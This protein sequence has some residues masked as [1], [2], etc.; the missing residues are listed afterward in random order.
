MLSLVRTKN[1]KQKF[2]FFRKSRALVPEAKLPHCCLSTCSKLIHT[3]AFPV[4]C[5]PNLL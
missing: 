1:N 2:L 3:G 5:L 4:W